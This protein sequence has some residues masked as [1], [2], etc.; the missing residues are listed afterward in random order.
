MD[1]TDE[2]RAALESSEYQRRL[3]AYARRVAAGREIDWQPAPD[4]RA[5]WVVDPGWAGTDVTPGDDASLGL[6]LGGQR[7]ADFRLS[8]VPGILQSLFEVEP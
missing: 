1:R 6:Y 7:I 4:A 8:D 2:D 5:E 3:D